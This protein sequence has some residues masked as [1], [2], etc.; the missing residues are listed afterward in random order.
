[1]SGPYLDKSGLALIE[2]SGGEMFFDFQG[3]PTTK[4][5]GPGHFGP[6]DGDP[7]LGPVFSHHYYNHALEDCPAAI[8]RTSSFQTG[9][10]QTV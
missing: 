9:V 7:A 6:Y 10:R 2:Q 3:G 5:I 4:F 1:M 8:G